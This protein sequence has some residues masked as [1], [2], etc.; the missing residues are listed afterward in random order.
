MSDGLKRSWMLFSSRLVWERFGSVGLLGSWIIEWLSLLTSTTLESSWAFE[1][2]PRARQT[3]RTAGSRCRDVD[4]SRAALSNL[5]VR[6]EIVYRNEV[7]SRFFNFSFFLVIRFSVKKMPR[8]LE[9]RNT[10]YGDSEF[11]NVEAFSVRVKY[12][13]QSNFFA[14]TCPPNSIL[15]HKL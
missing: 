10:I 9:G 13:A 1:M 5:L 4:R 6:C 12:C 3:P 14:V 2:E 11:F 8:I 15:I 7:F